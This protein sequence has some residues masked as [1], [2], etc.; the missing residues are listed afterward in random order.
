MA[1]VQV[2]SFFSLFFLVALAHSQRT[3]TVD[4]SDANSVTFTDGWST[5]PHSTAIGASF[6][7]TSKPA[8][9]VSIAL[10]RTSS[11]PP[12][13]PALTLLL[14]GTV[15]ARYIGFQLQSSATYSYCVDCFAAG[16]SNNL[17]NSTSVQVDGA[18]LNANDKGV[19]VRILVFSLSLG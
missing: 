4:Q 15:A 1:A 8:A 11:S 16:A 6:A 2:A 14:E 7:F 13:N 5:V 19:P 17:L 18:S 12:H 9:R 3:F 10:P